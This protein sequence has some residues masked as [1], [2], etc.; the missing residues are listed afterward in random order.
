M[1]EYQDYPRSLAVNLH[2]E[3]KSGYYFS[4]GDQKSCT[5]VD[6]NGKNLTINLNNLYINNFDYFSPETLSVS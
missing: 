2:K 6:L 3:H 4:I 5:C 1:L